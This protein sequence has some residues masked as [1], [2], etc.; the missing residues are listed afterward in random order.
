LVTGL[1][2]RGILHAHPDASDGVYSLQQMADATR[3]RGFSYFG[4]TDH[5]KSAHYAGGLSGDKKR[6]PAEADAHPPLGGEWE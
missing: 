4:V 3:K 5:S 6:A 2:I 1:D